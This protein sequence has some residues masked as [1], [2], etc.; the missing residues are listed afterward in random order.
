MTAT[1]D[2]RCADCGIDTSFESGV[3]HY[4]SARA[5][6]W[7]QATPDGALCLC[8]DC[9]ER[10]IGRALTEADILATPLEIMARFAGRAVEPLPPAERQQE[11]DSYRDFQRQALGQAAE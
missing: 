3:G 5:E 4:Y 10:R 2:G 7:R 1:Y 6:L 8:L 11:L 9:L